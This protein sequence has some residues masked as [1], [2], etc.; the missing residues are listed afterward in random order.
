[1]PR[2]C[3]LGG[4]LESNR[5]SLAI[6]ERLAKSDP[7][8]AGWQHDLALSLQQVGFV[9]VR[10][11]D[12]DAARAAYQRSREILARLTALAP[13]HAGFRRDLAWVEARLA[14]LR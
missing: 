4:A 5:A 6:F 1:M 11:G 10:Q 9:A 14:E 7:G 2:C 13:D 3:H 8:N 12:R